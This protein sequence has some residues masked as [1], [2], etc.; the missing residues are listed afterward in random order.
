MNAIAM[1]LE[2]CKT[3]S[4]SRAAENLF[5]SQPAVSQAIAQL[6]SQMSVLLLDRSSRS[7]NL[8]PDGEAFYYKASALYKDYLETQTMFET[9]ESKSLKIGCSVTTATYILPSLLST[10]K[11]EVIVRVE[12]AHALKDKLKSG[13][14]D[15]A[16]IEGE[17][18]LDS[19]ISY[20]IRTFEA[21][22]VASPE[23]FSS[24]DVQF[25]D[26]KFLLREAGSSYRIYFEN[27]ASHFGTHI[28]ASWQSVSTEALIQAA[29]HGHGI[30]LAPYDACKDLIESKLLKV[31]DI[32]F[33]IQH[34]KNALVVNKHR[35]HESEI[36]EFIKHVTSNIF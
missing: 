7:I 36:Q 15:L 32:D 11:D 22:F 5:V 28:K 4:I 24:H 27:I 30:A 35:I 14:L 34:D 21:V 8:T 16:F 1:F 19:F 26:H 9:P 29:V 10:Y 23:Y 12:N 17:L 33:P 25:K 20:P 2:V 13:S 18:S 3:G 6:E 31:Y